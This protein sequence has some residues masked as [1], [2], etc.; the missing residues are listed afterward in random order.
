MLTA[1]VDVQGDRLEVQILGFGAFEETWA[2]RYEVLP[3]D[4]A[5]QGVWGLLTGV[6]RESYRTDAGRELRVRLNLCR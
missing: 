6:L 1:G 2:I 5:Q 4:P 3:G